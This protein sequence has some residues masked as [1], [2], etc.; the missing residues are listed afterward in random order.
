MSITI[1]PAWYNLAADMPELS[2]PYKIPGSGE[3]VDAAELEGLFPAGV[4]DQEFNTSDRY[5]E[6]PENVLEFYAKWRP[7][8]FVRAS[9]F[10]KAIGTKARIYYK[11]EGAS[12][13]GSHKANSG[14]AQAYF[15]KQSGVKR[16]YSETG[17]GQWGSAI[18]MGSAFFGLDAQVF[19]VGGSYDGK[20]SRRILMESFGA[21]VDR[22]PTSQ[23]AAGRAVFDVD[24]MNS[25]NLGLAIAEAV[26]AAKAD[27]EGAYAMG[28][29]FNF[30]CLHQ[31]VIGQELKQQLRAAN[32][33]PDYLVSCIGGGSS[34][35]GL[36]FPFV[37]DD[38]APEFVA[39]ESSAVPKVTRG[40]FAYD[41]G[42]TAGT[43]PLLRMYT[44]GHQFAAPSIHAGG[45][46]YHGLSSQVSE[47][48]HRGGAQAVAVG[49]KEIFDA[50]ML[51]AKSEGLIPAPESAHSIAAVIDLAKK[52]SDEP[53]DIVF[54][55][56]GHGFFDL[57]AYSK[58]LNGEIEDSAV[59]PGSIEES[60][61][62]IPTL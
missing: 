30:V 31:T 10:E 47:L 44:L 13:I 61:E 56:T 14:V 60:L 42:D 58:H 3:D 8:P 54:C 21:K 46:R 9:S 52:H 5:I 2:A 53:K 35:A 51:F 25:G 43:T 40:R 18:A 29:A 16:V 48:I 36:V 17:A 22:S 15:A 7:T 38:Q 57:T 24:P 45:L 4:I 34:F 49:Q 32:I 55:L 41:H 62:K 11:Y 59:V 39:V 20:A 50:A 33:S 28:S 19:M 26:E 37:A 27:P 1:P 23:T 6:I 12:P